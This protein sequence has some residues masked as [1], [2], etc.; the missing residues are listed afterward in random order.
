[1]AK[2]PPFE[3]HDVRR[4]TVKITKA[5]DGLSEAL[6]IDPEAHHL[7]D[8]VYFVL[9]G[10][11]TQVN[12]IPVSPVDDDLARVHTVTTQEITRVES[13][14]V[15][16]FLAEAAD[17]IKRAKEEAEGIQRL[18]VGPFDD[19]ENDGDSNPA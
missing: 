5:G 8:E 19:E 11:V 15:E 9:R 17:R 10:I 13:D 1:M 3:G 2:L 6:K 14:D 7:G 16:S 18:D 4:S 12:H